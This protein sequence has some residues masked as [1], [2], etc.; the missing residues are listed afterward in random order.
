PNFNVKVD[1][2]KLG[3][4][5][6]KTQNTGSFEVVKPTLSIP[7]IVGNP[8]AG[9]TKSG[10]LSG[11]LDPIAGQV[12]TVR[13][14]VVNAGFG[15]L[16]Q[17]VYWVK[18]Q[19]ILTLQK[20]MVGNYQLVPI[21]TN[22]DT[23]FFQVPA[24]AIFQ[25]IPG[26]GSFTNNTSLFQYNESLFFTEY[27]MCDMCQINTPDIMRGVFYGC[28]GTLLGKCEQAVAQN[29]LRFS[30]RRPIL[31]TYNQYQI[32][33]LNN[34]S[35]ADYRESTPACYQSDGVKTIFAM[36]NSGTGPA[37]DVRFNVSTYPGEWNRSVDTATTQ[38]KIGWNGTWS[39]INAWKTTNNNQ[40]GSC[41]SSA[42]TIRRANYELGTNFLLNAGDTLYIRYTSIYSCGCNSLA[43]NQCGTMNYYY[44]GILNWEEGNGDANFHDQNTYS[45]P[46]GL[47]RW[48]LSSRA[49]TNFNAQMPNFLQG[50]ANIY[51][52]QT[53]TLS[54]N[55]TLFY[56]SWLD[57]YL[58]TGR[59]S[60]YDNATIRFYYVIDEGLDW[61][62][63]NGDVN[64]TDF[65]FYGTD[66][67]R[68]WKPSAVKYI[69]NGYGIKD[70]LVVDFAF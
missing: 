4:V 38:I 69:D 27:W 55:I 29:G 21:A 63:T 53:N 9:V 23:T 60:D 11:I 33:F 62:G 16:S 6:S 45:D 40:I 61:A 31:N 36:V 41:P 50:P 26:I 14:K 67:V 46:C 13:V 68:K 42:Q 51:P 8:I 28:D 58:G 57:N 43:A 64:T 25:A 30:I 2:E 12:D 44:Y 37:S 7:Q 56:N 59:R 54:T 22:G 47:A 24:A 17:M 39:H 34:G 18:D 19:P 10:S 35:R 5:V 3:V 65:A 1:Y 48:N 52:G 32:P 15:N 70:T 66:N 49:Q 20:V